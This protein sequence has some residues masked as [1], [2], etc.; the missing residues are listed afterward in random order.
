MSNIVNA[1]R[2]VFK[3]KEQYRQRIDYLNQKISDQNMEIVKLLNEIK[4]L[5]E[6]YCES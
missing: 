6:L 5:E 1:N 3:L 2:L 4:K